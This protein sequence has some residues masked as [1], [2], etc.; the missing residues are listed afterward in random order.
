MIVQI[1]HYFLTA[2]DAYRQMS[3]PLAVEAHEAS[4][5]LRLRYRVLCSMGCLHVVSLEILYYLSL[6]SPA[7]AEEN[8]TPFT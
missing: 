8:S 7:E 6:R 4:V 3:T 2:Q 1:G 5:D